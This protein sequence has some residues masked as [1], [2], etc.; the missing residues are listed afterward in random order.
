MTAVAQALT[1]SKDEHGGWLVWCPACEC[2]H[3]FD[4]RWK[5][6][7]DVVRPT[8]SPS[9]LVRTPQQGKPDRV[10]HSFLTGGVWQ[11][12]GDCTHEMAGK[13]VPA[14]PIPD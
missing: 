8:F 10:C 9:M 12:L 13:N 6:S 1:N 14:V 5:F 11:F 4:G 3:L 2:G 7:G